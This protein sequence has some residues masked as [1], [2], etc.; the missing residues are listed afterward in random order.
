MQEEFVYSYEEKERA[1]YAHDLQSFVL[2]REEVQKDLIR[3]LLK[4]DQ[5]KSYALSIK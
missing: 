2:L 3:I 4:E 1:K 5:K